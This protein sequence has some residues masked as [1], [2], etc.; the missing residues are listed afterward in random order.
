MKIEVSIPPIAPSSLIYPCPKCGEG[1]VAVVID[2]DEEVDEDE[3]YED[4]EYDF[5][6]GDEE[7]EPVNQVWRC[8]KCWYQ[9]VR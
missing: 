8:P 4:V 7:D 5:F 2:E 1:M 9:G 6:D 3:V